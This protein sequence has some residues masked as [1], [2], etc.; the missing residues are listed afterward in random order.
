MIAIDTSSLM[1]YLKG[2]EGAD[3]EWVDDAFRLQQAF[4]PPVVRT[5]ALS[6]PGLEQSVAQLVREI[7]VL[8][9]DSGF[10]ERAAATRRRVLSKRL[11]AR[12]AET[13]IAQSCL[14]YGVPLITRD[15]DF[16]H[17]AA[18]AGLKLL[19]LG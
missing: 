15:S 1:A 16:R 19:T 12:L 11:R 9:S 3:V 6:L 17:F 13:L 8:E 2:D 7:P 10:W 18:H 4:L 5:E 14:D